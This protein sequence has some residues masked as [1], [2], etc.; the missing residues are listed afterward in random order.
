MKRFSLTFLT[1][2]LI[3]Y[4]AGS[5]FIGYNIGWSKGADFSFD[6][7]ADTV[8]SIC[9]RQLRSDSTVSKLVFIKSDTTTFY[10]SKKTVV[11]K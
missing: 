5:F 4:T 10:L 11:F 8:I 1:L 9:N 7:T 2:I 3:I 6:V